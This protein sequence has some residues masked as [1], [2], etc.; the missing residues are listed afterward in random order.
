MKSIGSAGKTFSIQE[1]HSAADLERT[2]G[3]A[4][5]YAFPSAKRGKYI[6]GIA[7]TRRCVEEALRLRFKVFNIELG[8][9]LD[10]SRETGLDEDE[11]DDQMTHLVLF[12]KRSGELVGT[13]RMQTVTQAMAAGGIYSAREYDLEQLEP[14][15]DKLV[16]LGR[17]CLAVEHRKLAAIINLWL[18][19]GGFM[20]LHNSRYL[21]GCCSLTSANPEDHPQEG[22]PPSRTPPAR[23]GG[24]FLRPGFK[25]KR[26][27]VERHP[28]A[29]AIQGLHTHRLGGH[30]GTRHRPGVR[31]RGLPGPPGR[32]KKKTLDV[33]G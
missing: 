6:T 23:Q 16:E 20:N 33:L 21:F 28:P 30:L 24:L 29:Q 8:E 12:H 9:G 3:E 27:R 13:Y 7:G 19:I 32:V 15:F 1:I 4:D 18:G 2:R 5:I 14:Y 11:F 26:S 22:L 31:H 17:A 25:G 10:S